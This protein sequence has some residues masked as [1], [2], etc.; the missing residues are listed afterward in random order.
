VQYN[1]GWGTDLVSL[2][3]YVPAPGALEVRRQ[4]CRRD[5]EYL[6]SNT[7]EDGPVPLHGLDD[8]DAR[9]RQGVDGLVL[10]CR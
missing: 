1:A 6:R 3:N 2:E 5:S 9:D 8:S 10:E 4:L 7:D